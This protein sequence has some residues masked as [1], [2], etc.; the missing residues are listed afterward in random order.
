MDFNF[1]FGSGTLNPSVSNLPV[2]RTLTVYRH[3][4]NTCDLPHDRVSD[5]VVKL[6]VSDTVDD[7]HTGVCFRK[8]VRLRQKTRLSTSIVVDKVLQRL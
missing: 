4:W 8:I 5:S 3:D 6:L 1:G 7:S 2:P